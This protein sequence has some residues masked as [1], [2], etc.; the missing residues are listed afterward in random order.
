M[1]KADLE[2][3][4]AAAVFALMMIYALLGVFRFI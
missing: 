2:L 1:K 3:Y 4:A